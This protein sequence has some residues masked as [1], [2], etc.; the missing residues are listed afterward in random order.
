MNRSSILF[1]GSLLLFLFTGGAAM[2]QDDFDPD[3]PPEPQM[4]YRITM[5]S[6][7]SEAGYVSGA[8][9]YTEGTQVTIRTS[10]KSN[11]YTFLYWTKDGEVYS[12]EMSLTYTVGTNNAHFVAVYEYNPGN[13]GEPY[14][15][16]DRHLYLNCIPDEACSF[17]RTNGAM[18]SVN[19]AT[20]VRAYP[21]QG[22]K[23]QGWYEGDVLVSE[24]NPMS[25][26][27]PD[28]N[29]TLTAQFVY[30]PDNPDEPSGNQEDVE[31]GLIGDVN[32]DNVVTIADVTALVNIILGKDGRE[33]YQYDHTAANV[34]GDS[35]ITIADVT[36]LVNIILG[37]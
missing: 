24:Q 14:T 4:L 23:F 11:D 7:P 32:K 18:A 26:T 29:V 13:P 16:N 17:N 34:N 30:D 28:R 35:S 19:L 9:Q 10:L 6:S 31:N 27:M 2:A 3:N 1:L 33:P 36:A 12:D 37:K 5:E 25:Y 15:I 21:N 22:F 8:G 20:S